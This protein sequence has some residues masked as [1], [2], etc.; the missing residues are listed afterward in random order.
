MFAP[1]CCLTSLVR[2]AWK[3]DHRTRVRF[4]STGSA[5]Q[6]ASLSRSIVLRMP[7]VMSRFEYGFHLGVFAG[8]IA[9]A[10]GLLAG[11]FAYGALH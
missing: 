4:V 1:L 7:D 6:S 2:G 8:L 3:I 10:I 11:W 9:A 5:A